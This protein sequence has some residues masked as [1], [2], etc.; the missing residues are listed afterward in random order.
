M[1]QKQEFVTI[2][3]ASERLGVSSRTIRRWIL[4][5]GTKGVTRG[6]AKRHS[7]EVDISALE[8]YKGH[9]TQQTQGTEVTHEAQETQRTNSVKYPKNERK[10]KVT[11]R[12]DIHNIMDTQDIVPRDQYVSV[13]ESKDQIIRTQDKHIA[14]LENQLQNE[15]EQR[16]RSDILLAE[17][18]QKIPRLCLLY[19]YDAA[20][21]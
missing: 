13:L 18:L 11:D 8:R 19:T 7:L 3:H 2:K 17:T 5:I 9:N 14:T 6:T 4:D 20:D 10:N 15:R 12:A 16:K 1:P 21:E